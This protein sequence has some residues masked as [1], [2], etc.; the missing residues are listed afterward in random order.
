MLSYTDI[1]PGVFF[2]ED[3]VIYETIDSTFSKKSRQ[4]G[5]NQVKIKNVSTGATVTKTL[6]ASQTFEEAELEK[7]DYIFVYRNEKEIVIHEK[8]D[9]SKRIS[10]NID[11]PNLIPAKEI[12]TALIHNGEILNFI[13]P[14]KVK[15]KV[16]EAPP[17]IR[18][19]TSQGGTKQ[20]TVETGAKISTPL[21]IKEGEYI[22]VKTS[23]GKYIERAK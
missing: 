18:G 6:K 2:I 4:K 5:S 17:T 8:D 10:T 9:P 21:F 7:E 22:I 13:L 23:T 15:L 19:N 12:I 1:Q 11:I 14:I 20:V 16:T 3:G